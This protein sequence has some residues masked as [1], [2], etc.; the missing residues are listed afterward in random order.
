[1]VWSNM[2]YNGQRIET[3]KYVIELA[4]AQRIKLTE[5]EQIMWSKLYNK[6]V[7]GYRF[8]CQ[9]P[10]HRYILD[11]YCHKAMLA[12]EIDGDVHKSRKEYDA[13]RDRFMESVGIR[14]LRFSANEVFCDIDTIINQIKNVLLKQAV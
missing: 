1:M 11:F 9:H 4:R 8:R 7:N 6:Q 3:P 2:L 5:S 10:V 13:Y 12:I 14:T